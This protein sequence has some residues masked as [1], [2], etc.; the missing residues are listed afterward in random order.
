MSLLIA[1]RAA[2]IGGQAVWSERLLLLLPVSV[3]AACRLR[4]LSSLKS[5][6][7]ADANSK[8]ERKE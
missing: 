7:S 1:G 5:F 3:T 8:K 4:R 6:D 2:Q